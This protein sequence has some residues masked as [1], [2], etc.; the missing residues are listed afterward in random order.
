MARFHLRLF[1][2]GN[3]TVGNAHFEIL[4]P[5]TS[6]HQVLSWEFA[7][8]FV[9]TDMIRCGL[10]DEGLPMAPTQAINP[11]PFHAIPAVIYNGLPVELRAAIGGPLDNVTADVPIATDGQATIFNL[12]ASLPW[13]PGV[14]VENTISVYDQV[15]PK[16]F[17]S[18]GPGDYVHVGGPVSL[19]QIKYLSLRERLKNLARH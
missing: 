8:Q 13:Q 18:S 15:M 9:M 12:A 4:I 1:R 11:S 7:E 2:L 10:L 3:W 5:N 16:P 19:N 17:C 14:V 6:D